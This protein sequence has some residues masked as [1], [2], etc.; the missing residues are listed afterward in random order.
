MKAI[1]LFVLIHF[2]YL[3]LHAQVAAVPGQLKITIESVR[4][5]NKS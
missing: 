2:M 3:G 1:A 5:I 4:C